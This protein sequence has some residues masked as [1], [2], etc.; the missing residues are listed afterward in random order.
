[1]DKT[2]NLVFTIVSVEPN[3]FRVFLKV[4]KRK[5]AVSRR[6]ARNVAIP[7][8]SEIFGI[9]PTSNCIVVSD[10]RSEGKYFTD[11]VQL[12]SDV[13]CD[14]GFS[15]KPEDWEEHVGK[16]AKETSNIFVG[17]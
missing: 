5:T 4:R 9:I 2:Y 16:V 7:N 11:K 1:M 8:T 3:C 6:P 14:G 12:G 10:I 13:R 17:F 15:I